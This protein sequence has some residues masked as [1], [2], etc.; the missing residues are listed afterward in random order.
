MTAEQSRELSVNKRALVA[1]VDSRQTDV[2]V[3][4]QLGAAMFTDR[5]RRVAHV[6]AVGSGCQ[7]HVGSVF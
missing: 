1:P 7:C 6:D 3:V 5:H 2:L 4:G